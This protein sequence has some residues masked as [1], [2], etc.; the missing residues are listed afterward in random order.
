[1]I[2]FITQLAPLIFW[3]III[4]VVFAN[5]QKKQKNT[6]KVL[7]TNKTTDFDN[8]QYEQIMEQIALERTSQSQERESKEMTQRVRKSSER[9]DMA[10][11][12]KEADALKK[13][14]TQKNAKIHEQS[15]KS[16]KPP[17]PQKP[18]KDGKSAE[19]EYAA[20]SQKAKMNSLKSAFDDAENLRNAFII[21]EIF[22][23]KF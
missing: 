4:Y 17:K 13:K 8:S 7:Q 10:Y 23:K 12:N 5:T 16:F 9:L 22:K 14:Q 15:T 2:N 18:S 20:Y 19:D 11:T 1:M 3:G 6:P 21:S